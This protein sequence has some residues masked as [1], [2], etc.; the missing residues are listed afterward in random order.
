M[1]HDHYNILF[2]IIIIIIYYYYYS[3][4]FIAAVG[5]RR[6]R[7][8]GCLLVFQR[9]PVPSPTFTSALPCWRLD[10]RQ[11]FGEQSLVGLPRASVIF[12]QTHAQTPTT[13]HQAMEGGKTQKTALRTRGYRF[14]PRGCYRSDG[15]N[16]LRMEGP[17]QSGRLTAW[18]YIS[19]AAP[20]F[21]TTP[22]SV[23]ISIYLVPFYETCGCTAGLHSVFRRTSTVFRRS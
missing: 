17:I 2:I 12:T 1:D 13:Q 14:K 16:I 5:C 15:R 7:R 11:L 10:L 6:R 4:S 22:C 19:Y 20:S 23:L 8:S 3:S 18:T 9:L 21:S